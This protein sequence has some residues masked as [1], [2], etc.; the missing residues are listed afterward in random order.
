M[1][2]VTVQCPM[3]TFIFNY[4]RVRFVHMIQIKINVP[5]ILIHIT[6][7]L[8]QCRLINYTLYRCAHWTSIWAWP[9]L[10]PPDAA[11]ARPRSGWL[12]LGLGLTYSTPYEWSNRQACLWVLRNYSHAQIHKLKSHGIHL[13]LKSEHN[14][15]STGNYIFSKPKAYM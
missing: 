4:Y 7:W 13:W 9:G 5:P 1:I 8:L 6:T 11:T 3:I 12:Q 10:T 14:S 15:L 2:F